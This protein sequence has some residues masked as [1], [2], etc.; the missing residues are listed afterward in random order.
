MSIGT[1]F[2]Y[3]IGRRDAIEAI[4]GNRHALWIGFLFVLSAGFAREYDGEDLWNEPWHLLLPLGA[5]LISSFVLFLLAHGIAASKGGARWGD[6][7]GNYASFLGLFWMTAPLAWIYAIPYE[8]FLTPLEAMQA[9]LISLGVVSVWRVALMVRVLTVIG[10]YSVGAAICLVMVFADAVALVLLT[11]LPFHLI[12]VMG[13]IRIAE[14]D[15]LLLAVG[16]VVLQ[17][18]GCTMP[19]WFVGAGVVMERSKPVWR[20][21]PRNHRVG[22][23]P[24]LA[25]ASLVLWSFILPWT[26][27]PQARRRA[28]EKLFAEERVPEAVAEMSRH[29]QADYPPGWE[30]PP[31]GFHIHDPNDPLVLVL[32]ELG[33]NDHAEWVRGHYLARMP[34]M[35]RY[36]DFLT[37]EALLR[38]ATA[39]KRLPGG[40]RILDDIE[41]NSAEYQRKEIRRILEGKPKDKNDR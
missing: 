24:W 26:Q 11:T 8:R 12:D 23:L 34:R 41:A 14:R 40:Q 29:A 22:T 33:R 18:G 15:E 32:E 17:V 16:A 10:G 2:R 36:R 30:P 4:A 31:R 19:F 7:Y 25:V 37:E 9:N 5:S 1:L 20:A 3:L 27:P 21:F 35:L 13:G 39:L 38:V 6:F 28:V